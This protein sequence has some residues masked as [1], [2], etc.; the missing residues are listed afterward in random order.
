MALGP[1][2]AVLLALAPGAELSAAAAAS[3]RPSLCRPSGVG[4]ENTVWSRARPLVVSRFCGALARG[5]AALEGRPEQALALAEQ[6]RAEDPKHPVPRLLA[7]RALFRLGRAKQAWPLFEPFLRPDAV[8]ID[9]ARSLFDAARVAVSVGELDAAE[10]GY[11][12]LVARAS[13]LGSVAERRVATIEA[14]SLSLA[15]G[16]AGVDLALGYLAEAR[17]VPLSGER[18]MVLALSAL[19]LS[20]AGQKERARALL[21]EA[22]GPWDLESALTPAERARVASTTL[23]SASDVPESAAGPPS[24]SRIHLIDGELHAAIAL[25]AENRDAALGRAH[26]KAFLLSPRGQGPW[27]EHARRSLAE[28]GGRKP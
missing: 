5:F 14:A 16:P 23:D 20:R 10:R 27:A 3:P 2:F 8:S 19:A 21:K 7:G 12:L 1:G 17:A 22:D 28:L 18:D 9:D 11:R 26:W 15:R 6:A 4:L 24:R 25:L 13:L